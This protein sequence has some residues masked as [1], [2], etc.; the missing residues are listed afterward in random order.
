MEEIIS[1]NRRIRQRFGYFAPGNLK[2]T[3]KLAL[4]V[5]TR[6]A[7]NQYCVMIGSDLNQSYEKTKSGKELA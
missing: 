5:V 2:L 4:K 7:P 6:V 3:L 1:Q